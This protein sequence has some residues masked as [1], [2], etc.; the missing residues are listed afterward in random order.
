MSAVYVF[1]ALKAH[2]KARGLTYQDLATKI[3]ISHATVKRIFSE[4]DCTIER[5]MEICAF[6]QIELADVVRTVPKKSNLIEHLTWD[7][8]VDFVKNKKLLMTAVCALSLW[9]FEEML[10]YF[11]LEET[12]L[13]AL[14]SQLD[15]MGFLSWQANNHYRLLVARDFAWIVDGPIMRFVR[16][17]ADDFF[18]HRF[19]APGEVLRIVNV[20]IS[21]KAREK[22]K[23]RLEQ[24]AQEYATQVSEDADLP[25]M[26]RPPLSICIAT[27]L[28]IP[29]FMRDLL[30]PEINL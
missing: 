23:A 22:L 26:E 9:R 25:L 20:R 12:E 1:A 14:F 30:R 29:N 15:E 21:H 11:M 19:E 17:M 28:W 27:R 4:C 6:L 2:L 18:D 24:I 8:E 13:I 5:L 3:G 10:K 16:G 7:Q